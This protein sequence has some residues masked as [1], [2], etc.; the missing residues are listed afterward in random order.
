MIFNNSKFNSHWPTKALN[1]LGTFNRGK[2]KHRPRNDIKLF[3]NGN[4]PLIQTGDV[5]Q[6]NIF[7][8]THSNNYN[9]FG[10]A[11]SKLWTKGTLCIT[12]AANIAET[13][14]LNY[15]M[16]FPDSVVGFNAFPDECSE[17][18]MHYIFTYIR[19]GIQSRIQ[20][21]IQD[22][23]NI[24]YL[25]N[26]KFK[27]PIKEERKQI[28]NL[29]FS[30]DSKI[31][32]NNKINQELEEMAKTLYDYWFVQFDFPDPSSS[33]ERNGK[34]YKSSGGN[35][36][37]NDELKREIPE[38]WEVERLSEICNII[39]G[40]AFKSEWYKE[41]GIKI[42]RTKNFDGG[43]VNLKDINFLEEEFALEFE[44]Y[45]LNQFDFLMVMVGASTGKHS[46]V[47]S[48]ILPAL[49]N[50]NM[51]RFVSKSN[52]QLFLNLKLKRI[53]LELE[54][55]TNGSARGFFQKDT[56]L[57]KRVGIPTKKITEEFCSKMEPIFQNIDNNLNQNQKLSELRDWLLPMLMN[58]Q[59]S[60]GSAEQEVES[61]GLVAE[62]REEYKK[63]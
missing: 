6:A 36:V 11:Q 62:G 1:E 20:G 47:N 12:I 5:K 43:Y 18:F 27:I 34:P 52:N 29:L 25:T 3:K 41:N 22:N 32:I 49:Q 61:L 13:S 59:V 28:E 16:C 24:E 37:F 38:G 55:T 30:L 26:L 39:N 54:N 56:F 48:N 2:S 45:Q 35:M 42:I 19:A 58:G 50:Q 44:K 40:Y 53:I 21:S 4:I 14:M 31:E 51:W 17:T 7:I 10:L 15:D 57:N 63:E 33:S 23:I 60:V 46:V 9:E 8:K